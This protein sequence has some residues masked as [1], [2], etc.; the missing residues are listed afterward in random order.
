MRLTLRTNRWTQAATLAAWV[1]SSGCQKLPYIDQ[2]KSVPHDP[3]GATA[4]EDKE[5]KQADFLS[6]SL[7]MQMPKVHKP[8]TTNDPEA[9]E[10]WPMTLQEAIRIGLDNSEIV[11]VIPFGAQGIPIGGFEPSPLNTGAGA[12][13]AGALGAGSLESVYDPAIQETQIAQA[14]S[15]FDTAFTTNLTWGKSTQPF[16]NA[17]QGGTLS[18]T[19]VKTVVLS[20]QDT[21]NF[22]IGLQKRNATGGLMSIVHN[23]QWLYQ[24]S[25][26]LTYPSAYTT[27]LQLSLT[28][29]LMGS[30]P[31]PGQAAGPPVGLE[32]NR[33]PIVVARL[34][35]DAAVWRFKAG[36][37]AHVRS[38]EQQYW[39]LA[40]QHVQLWSSEKAVELAREIV[41]REQAELVVGKGTV[42]DVAEAQ[43]RLEQFNLDLVTK[44]SDVITTERQLR[45]ILGLPPAD[46]RR[47]IP[48]TP[49]AEA[50]LEPDWE[51][52][53]AQMVT[54]QP[55]IVQQQ[56]L[57]R[58]AELQLLVARNQLLPQLNLSVLYQLNGLG[59]QL[60]NA[61]A[62]MT[63]ATI[64]ALEPVVSARERAAGLQ[65]NPGFYNDFRTWQVGFS[66]QM[67]LGMRSPLANTRNAQYIL[68]RQRAYLQQI[69]HQT[70]H[71]L[72][73]FFLEVDAN[74][75]QFKTASRLRA[76]AA[77]RLEAQRAYYEEGR[78]TIDRFLD[79]VS[80]Y[81]Q[82]VA[83][84][85]QFKTTYNIS[86]VALEEAKGTLL[87]YNNIAVAEGPH[88]RKAY[89]QAKDIQDAHRKIPIPPDGPKYRQRVTGPLNPDPVPPNPPP[90]VQPGSHPPLPAPVGP[91]G[92]P[93]TAVPPYRPAGE[94]PILSQNPAPTTPGTLPD[95]TLGLP[96]K[97][98]GD[99][100]PLD[101]STTPAGGTP[102]QMS[103][104]A[105]AALPAIPGIESRPNPADSQ[106]T[107][108]PTAGLTPAPAAAVAPAPMAAPAQAPAPTPAPSPAPESGPAAAKPDAS[109]ELPELPAEINLPPLPK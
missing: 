60:D 36:V 97:P 100:P 18:L 68:L 12:G 16:N 11:R 27:N 3:M 62:V 32:A 88:P 58:I 53:L 6:S 2:S 57:V 90:D 74:Y 43:Q 1:F 51:S 106:P 28:Q 75:K 73:R 80:Q 94:A 19:G 84:E 101:G 81:A 50:R 40:Q 10:I 24:N 104:P 85:A 82:A 105:P 77:Q 37:L 20:V 83:Q 49:P 92:P 39:S 8:R 103:G 13:V 109:D 25:T 70:T 71:S 21:A 30:A 86:I 44:T 64:K 4:L 87:A 95:P 93:P 29:P 98:A 89:V 9:E 55:D 33:A 31:L 41:N 15:V 61:E 65:S 52:S 72:A 91:L 14:L 63:G 107:G 47:I 22:A 54:F 102:D 17:V 69:V 99:K 48:V 108:G 79:A 66:F 76:A 96:A 35:A 46:N 56:L 42:A 67:P 5:V 78:I 23:V 34:N 59:Q 26:F 7:T 45:N 38:I